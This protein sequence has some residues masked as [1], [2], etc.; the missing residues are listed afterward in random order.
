MKVIKLKPHLVDHGLF[1]PK[2]IFKPK[3]T[4][5][6][7]TPDNISSLFNIVGI[8]LLIIGSL[9]LYQR[10]SDKYLNNV[11]R[12]HTILEFSQYVNHALHKD[13]TDQV[14]LPP[15]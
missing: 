7:P 14:V 15:Q 9:Y 10:Y 11:K 12:Q 4:F 5:K 8:L 3:P 6:P 13:P 2:P 1:K